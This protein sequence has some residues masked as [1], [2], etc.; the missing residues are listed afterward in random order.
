MRHVELRQRFQTYHD[1]LQHVSRFQNDTRLLAEWSKYLCILLYGCIEQSV[2]L[3][4]REYARRRCD[5]SILAFVEH[6]LER[7]NKINAIE[8][9]NIAR[10]FNAD[11]ANRMTGADD[12]FTSA[13]NSVVDI[14]NRIAH[15]D[16]VGISY[17][18]I[19]DYHDRVRS[20]IELLEDVFIP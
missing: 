16:Y 1:L 3:I 17:H 15:G 8:V 20:Y 6:K 12:R 10:L 14:R 11:L 13:V 2:K 4:F 9:V 18:T 7:Y 19:R 5:L